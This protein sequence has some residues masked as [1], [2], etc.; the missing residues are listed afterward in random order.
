M[1]LTRTAT[2]HCWKI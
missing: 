2:A 1:M